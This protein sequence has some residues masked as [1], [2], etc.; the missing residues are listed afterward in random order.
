MSGLTLSSRTLQLLRR[1]RSDDDVLDQAPP[2]DIPVAP[3]SLLAANVREVPLVT[4]PA[5]QI[6]LLPHL[7]NSG[8]PH[9]DFDPITRECIEGAPPIEIGRFVDSKPTGRNSLTDRITFKSK[10]VSRVH[11]EI[12]CEANGEV[13][14]LPHL[15]IFIIIE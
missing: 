8:A 6:R 1:L 9:F 4:G 7:E 14:S 2:A 3:N 12:W 10:V 11:A 5:H 15:T 13:C